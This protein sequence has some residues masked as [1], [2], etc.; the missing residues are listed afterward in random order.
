VNI[1]EA[2]IYALKGKPVAKLT[3]KEFQKDGVRLTDKVPAFYKKEYGGQVESEV[4]IVKLDLEGVKDDI[5]HHLS[6]EKAAAFTAVPEVLTKGK[7][8]DYQKD[9]KGRGY[10]SFVFVAPIEIAGERYIEEVVVKERSNRRGLYLH[11]VEITKRLR[12]IIQ[13]PTKGGNPPTSRLIL[14]DLIAKS[15]QKNNN[16]DDINSSFMN[17]NGKF[18]T[19]RAII[20]TVEHNQIVIIN[21][22]ADLNRGQERY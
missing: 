19:V 12:D 3:G 15:K 11:E 21:P 9:W 20:A 18:I 1:E 22:F 5:G 13:T 7:I 10:D 4:G 17:I 16:E 6:K 2:Q 8:I 14:A